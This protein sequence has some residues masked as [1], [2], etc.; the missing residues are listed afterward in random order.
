MHDPPLPYDLVMNVQVRQLRALIAVADEGTFTDAAIALRISQAA[1]SRSVATL[2]SE[3]GVRLVRRTTRQANPTAVGVRVIA[4][5]RRV[6]A[7]LAELERLVEDHASE[8]RVGYSWSALGRHTLTTQRRWAAARPNVPLVFV[9]VNTPTAGL[10]DGSAEVAVLRRPLNDNRFATA[11]IGTERRFAAIAADDQW[12]RRRY[13]RMADFAG[14]TVAV[15]TR[16][17][18]TTPDLWPPGSGPAEMRDTHSIDEWLTLIAG[19]QA[20]GITPEATVAQF[21][22]PG[23]VYRPVRDAEPVQVWLAWWREDPPAHLSTLI[24]LIREAYAT[25][26]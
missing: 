17:G 11:L 1:V 14:R 13:L 18:T 2:E 7:E 10:S 3:L 19:G 26:A 20:V 16:T 4:K 21:P 9:H 24:R 15:Q 12:A 25:D 5:A 8:L 22:R 6:L 23:L